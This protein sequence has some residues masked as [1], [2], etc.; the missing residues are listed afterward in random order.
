MAW[1]VR[2][3]QNNAALL[4]KHG[5]TY[6]PPVIPELPAGKA[7]FTIISGNPGGNALTDIHSLHDLYNN[8]YEKLLTAYQGREQARLAREAELKAHPPQP[9]DIVLNHWR[10]QPAKLDKKDGGAR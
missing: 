6:T 3:S 5:R 9:K 8:E 2:A 10:V 7:T 4:A 1:G